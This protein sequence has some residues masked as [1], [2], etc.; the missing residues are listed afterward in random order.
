MELILFIVWLITFII[1][2]FI[3]YKVFFELKILFKNIMQIKKDNK[4]LLALFSVK[5]SNITFIFFYLF[6]IVCFA[7][8]IHEI[9]WVFAYFGLISFEFSII[10][11]PFYLAGIVATLLTNLFIDESYLNKLLNPFDIRTLSILAILLCVILFFILFNIFSFFSKLA[12]K[13]KNNFKNKIFSKTFYFIIFL[14]FNFLYLLLFLGFQ[15]T[16][17]LVYKSKSRI[18]ELSS[19]NLSF[20]ALAFC[21]GLLSVYFIKII[22]KQ[23]RNCAN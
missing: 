15:K 19:E 3:V 17:W 14:F 13:V 22:I 4:K 7:A 2:A 5:I 23:N 9:F 16:F 8:F 11:T 21:L 1:F 18:F 10:L 20:L 6:I 12:K